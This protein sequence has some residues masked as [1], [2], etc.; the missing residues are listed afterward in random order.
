MK[1]YANR[2]ASKY[3]R[4]ELPEPAVVFDDLLPDL[5][6]YSTGFAWACC[7]FHD[8]HNPSLCVNLET[9]WYKCQSSSCGAS[10]SNIVGFVG[11]LLGYEYGEARNYLEQHY[12]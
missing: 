6:E 10:G 1:K 11:A 7:P 5:R 9:G 12:G 2:R 4:R 8:D 3:A